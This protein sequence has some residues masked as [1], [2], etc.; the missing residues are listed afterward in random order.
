MK[1]CESCR[2][3]EEQLKNGLCWVC[4]RVEKE[5]AQVDTKFSLIHKSGVD[6]K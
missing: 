2:E 4:Y 1:Q 5:I 3:E 6:K